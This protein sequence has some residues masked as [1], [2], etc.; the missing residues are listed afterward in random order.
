MSQ[1][2][3]DKISKDLEAGVEL[4]MDQMPDYVQQLV[5]EIAAQAFV[6]KWQLVGGII[7]EAYNNGYLSA[8]TLDPAWKDGFKPSESICKFCKKPY[9][10]VRVGQLFCCNDCGLGLTPLELIEPII[11]EEEKKESKNAKPSKS[12]AAESALTKLASV[13]KSKSNSTPISDMDNKKRDKR[14]DSGWSEPDL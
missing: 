12:T 11:E 2:T 7:F 4:L 6:P 8:Y 9:M 5:V 1:E 14:K 10:P 13:G 3:Q